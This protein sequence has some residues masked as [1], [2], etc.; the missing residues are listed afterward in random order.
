MSVIAVG[1]GEI[2]LVSVP[3]TFP[4]ASFS[5]SV[6]SKGPCGLS[7]VIDQAPRNAAASASE[8][9]LRRHDSG[10]HEQSECSDA[11]DDTRLQFHDGLTLL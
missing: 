8:R 2:A 6:C 4:P 11:G 7:T 1:S 3:V 9:G 5:S 10:N